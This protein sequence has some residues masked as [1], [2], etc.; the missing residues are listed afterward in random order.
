MPPVPAVGPKPRGTAVQAFP[1]PGSAAR[2]TAAAEV[3]SG[4]CEGSGLRR[5]I[6]RPGFGDLRRRFEA[7]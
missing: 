5:D 3:S 2:Q 4:R 6:L 7:A 1:P